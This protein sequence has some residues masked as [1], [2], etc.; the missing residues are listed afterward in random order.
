MRSLL[1]FLRVLVSFVL[2]VDAARASDGVLAGQ[3][4][5][6]ATG[7]VAV[8]RGVP[9]LLTFV[10]GHASSANVPQKKDRHV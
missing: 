8:V 3:V 10:A 5:D 6:V 2:R 9:D 7:D 1:T 4:E